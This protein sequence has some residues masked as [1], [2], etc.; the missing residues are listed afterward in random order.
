[1]K[2]NLFAHITKKMSRANLIRATKSGSLDEFN[3][4]WWDTFPEPTD[5]EGYAAMVDAFLAASFANVNDERW[6]DVSVKIH[7]CGAC[8]GLSEEDA[9]HV[10]MAGALSRKMPD[11]SPE[12]RQCLWTEL[13][14]HLQEAGYNEDQCKVLPR[15][16]HHFKVSSPPTMEST[17]APAS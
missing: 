14:L 12:E 8:F 13:V 15:A 11:A 10:L 16:R 1:M 17:D 3:Q 9:E 5:K 6:E 4:A 7:E 2:P